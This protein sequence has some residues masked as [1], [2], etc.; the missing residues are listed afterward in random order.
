MITLLPAYFHSEAYHQP[1]DDVNAFLTKYQEKQHMTK[2]KRSH[3]QSHEPSSFEV[4][5]SHFRGKCRRNVHPSILHHYFT[6]KSKEAK[7][8][9]H[10]IAIWSHNKFQTFFQV[11]HSDK[12]EWGMVLRFLIQGEWHP[13]SSLIHPPLYHS[14]K[15]VTVWDRLPKSKVDKTACFKL[16]IA[17]MI[18]PEGFVMYPL[19]VN[20]KAPRQTF[21]QTPKHFANSWQLPFGWDCGKTE[22]P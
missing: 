8:P 12:G 17:R 22:V 19:D 14:N 3:G 21:W 16:C 5:S 15:V 4:I 6:I 1:N 7:R 2:R 20:S 10:H 11:R 9:H 13:M 18:H